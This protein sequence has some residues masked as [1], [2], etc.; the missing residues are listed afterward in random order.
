MSVNNVYELKIGVCIVVAQLDER[1]HQRWACASCARR[2]WEASG[3]WR[4]FDSQLHRRRQMSK[5]FCLLQQ[6]SF[7]F[8]VFID[9]LNAFTCSLQQ[10]GVWCSETCNCSK[11]TKKEK[12][13]FSVWFV[14]DKW[15]VDRRNNGTIRLECRRSRPI[16]NRFSTTALIVPLPVMFLLFVLSLGW[17][18]GVLFWCL[19]SLLGKGYYRGF[20][21]AKVICVFLSIHFERI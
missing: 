12:K 21:G 17:L 4:R 3:E 2:T 16:S 8:S 14:C 6:G 5:R 13:Q 20:A 15:C 9:R 18:F 19:L 10:I 7:V 11:G 1:R